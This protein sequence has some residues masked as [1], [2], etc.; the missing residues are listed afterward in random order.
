V[1]FVIEKESNYT[2]LEDAIKAV[3]E[4][5]K[6][7]KLPLNLCELRLN[8][9]YDFIIG[10]NEYKPT[11]WAFESLLK[12]LDIP[13]RFG[14]K[15]PNDLLGLVVHRL[16][17]EAEK[18]DKEQVTMVVQGN[19]VWN[20][21]K[22]DPKIP[23]KEILGTI[24]GNKNIIKTKVGIR[25]VII[26]TEL[27]GLTV[28]P[29]IGDVVRMGVRTLVS[30]TGGPKPT[31]SLMMERLTCLNGAVASEK[32]G[33]VRWGRS[34]YG[35]SDFALDMSILN[36]RLELLSNAMKQ[37]PTRKLSDMTF[38]YVWNSVKKVLGDA[39]ETD[40]FLT[41]GLDER[42]AYIAS[43]KNRV[44]KQLAAG[45]TE[46]NAWKAYNQVSFLARDRSY[47]ENDALARVAG[48]IV[49]STDVENN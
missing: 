37:L 12:A 10:G 32:Y 23:L 6:H 19:D 20:I 49:E 48:I 40:K 46:V 30:E 26:D 42:E 39:D 33:V 41:V 8:T 25:G 43:A 24:A 1:D 28:E 45:P 29:E 31:A 22:K 47:K 21:V 36:G 7:E 3:D 5:Y 44:A 38:N 2:N 34:N 18:E 14:K 13:V 11:E 15:I 4:D 27:P 17:L 16:E 9:S 35:T